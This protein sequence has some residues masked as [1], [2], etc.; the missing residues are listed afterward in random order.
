MAA[1][2]SKALEQRLALV[3]Q[4]P[5]RPGLLQP[6]G[7]V[8]RRLHH[9]PADHLGVVEA[10]ELAAAQGEGPCAVGVEPDRSVAPWQDVLLDAQ[11]GYEEAVDHVLGGHRQHD[12][13]ALGD[14]QVVDLALASGVFELPHPLLGHDVDGQRVRG[15]AAEV[16]VEE[17]PVDEEDQDQEEG[18]DGPGR[19]DG[20]GAL[21]LAGAI[22]S[23]PAAIL[24]RPDEE[25]DE[26]RHGQE[27]QQGGHAGEQPVHA[28]GVDR[29]PD[30][31]ER[32][33]AVQVVLPRR[34]PRAR[35]TATPMAKVPT[36]AAAAQRS[37]S[38]TARL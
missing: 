28:I 21:E 32:E 12:V 29:G 20:P 27:K 25:Q 24:Q 10:A 15:R 11:L 2:A 33:R 18:D 23:G 5:G 26:D 8:G 16:Q 19:L 38:V 37:N 3:G 31:P 34:R 35:A 6:S 7:V 30:R 1:G 9:Q 17:G 14:M 4:G 13:L 22:G 36:E